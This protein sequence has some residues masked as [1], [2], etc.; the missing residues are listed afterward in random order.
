MTASLSSTPLA[1]GG[2]PAETRV[3]ANGVRLLV[4][5]EPGQAVAALG[6]WVENGSRYEVPNEAGLAHL[7]EHMVF[8][9]TPEY[10]VRE[11]AEAMDR[12]GCEVDAWTGREL[13][14][15]TLEVLREDT[16]QALD[17]LM[18]MVARP[19]LPVEE[20]ERE[21][22]VV[23]AEAAM[24]RE[25]PESWL[26]D[27]LVRSVWAD[28]PAGWPVLGDPEVISAASPKSLAD[29]HRR[30]YT[31]GRILLAV[32]GNLDADAVAA[33]AEAGLGHLPTGTR[34]ADTAATFH[35]GSGTREGPAE[36]CHLAVAAPAPARTDD[37]RFAAGVANHLLG[38][39]VTSRLFRDLREER[40]LAYAVY[41]DLDTLRD[42]G[43][44]AVYLA[45]PPE[46]RDA[47]RELVHANLEKARTQ[48][49]DQADVERAR[50]SLRAALLRGGETLEQRLHQAVGDHLYHGRIL[51]KDERLE[52]LQGVDGES[53]RRILDRYWQQSNELILDPTP[54]S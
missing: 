50:H 29:Y 20:L 32:A 42:C 21:R 16:D 31:G 22:G 2:G 53:V 10:S 54:S 12:L 37:E 6:I 46:H 19:R 41:S 44:W 7:L 45:C 1:S 48:G 18:Q 39:S 51:P 17:L 30:H 36:Q 9:G 25:E 38:G 40:G 24:V 52:A 47:A 5:P 43:L 3:L 23:A 27:E 33:Q 14:A 26:L 13:T 15:Y 34:P 4:L 8:K 35:T 11:L 28:H 49:F